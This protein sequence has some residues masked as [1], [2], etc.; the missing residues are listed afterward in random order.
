MKKS[1]LDMKSLSAVKPVSLLCL[2]AT[3][4][5]NN[6]MAQSQYFTTVANNGTYSWDAAN[7]NA[8]PASGNTGPYTFNWT[9]GIL[10]GF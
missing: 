5:A 2:L 8:S 10:Q 4:L 9:P 1:P 6:A 7:W 3:V